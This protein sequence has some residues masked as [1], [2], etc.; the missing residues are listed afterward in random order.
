MVDPEQTPGLRG[1]SRPQVKLL[2]AFCDKYLLLQR[3][4]EPHAGQWEF[5]GGKLT[6]EEHQQFKDAELGGQH[7][8]ATIYLQLAAYRALERETG[9]TNADAAIDMVLG[10]VNRRDEEL[11]HL[12]LAPTTSQDITL[13][14]ETHKAALWIQRR[15]LLSLPVPYECVGADGEPRSGVLGPMDVLYYERFVGFIRSKLG[16]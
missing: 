8:T 12:L 5:P 3:A 11:T 13:A 9:L 6:P 10:A 14:I 16:R 7:H 4:K 1:S 2:V 15:D